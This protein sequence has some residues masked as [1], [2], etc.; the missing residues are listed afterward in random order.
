MSTPTLSDRKILIVVTNYGVERDEIQV[1][2][3]RLQQ[4][5]ASVT[6]AAP[7]AGE[8]QSLVGD[9]DPGPVLT[10]DTSLADVVPDDYDALVVPGGTINADA[11]RIDPHAQHIIQAFARASRPVAAIC[12]APWLLVSSG[13]ASGKRLTSWKSLADD[14][15]NS[16][17]EWTDEPLVRDTTGGW[18]LIT[19]RFP[20]DLAQF[21]DAIEDELSGAGRSVSQ[22]S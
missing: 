22:L 21:V 10:A 18:T 11:L 8:V 20:G 4:A 1:P 14:L 3:Q 7:S 16:G 17:A 19:S 5:G 12:H 9:K 6:V 15:R 13:L 2:L